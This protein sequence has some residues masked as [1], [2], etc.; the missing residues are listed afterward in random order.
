MQVGDLVRSA[1]RIPQL[2]VVAGDTEVGEHEVVVGCPPDPKYAH[3]RAVHRGRAAIHAQARGAGRGNVPVAGLGR[4]IEQSTTGP[5][6][7]CPSRKT[8]SELISQRST[9]LLPRNV[10]LV[11]PASSKIQPFRVEPHD[12]VPP[13]HSRVGDYDVALWIAADCT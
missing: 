6:S 12:R 2:G 9:R 3:R 11:L 13:R 10:P 8:Q 5:S 1:T 7:G 4:M